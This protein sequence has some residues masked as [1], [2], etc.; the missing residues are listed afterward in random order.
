MEKMS[1]KSSFWQFEKDSGQTLG[2]R[3][4]RLPEFIVFYFNFFKFVNFEATDKLIKEK[5]K[6]SCEMFCNRIES[7]TEEFDPGDEI[8]SKRNSCQTIYWKCIHQ[9]ENRR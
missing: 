4:E 9:S 8:A 2:E 6:G 1:F 3:A 7:W 5:N